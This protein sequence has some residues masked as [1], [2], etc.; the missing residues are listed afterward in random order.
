[1]K[2]SVQELTNH[3][4]VDH[5]L[6]ATLDSTEAFEGP[7]KLLEIWFYPNSESVPGAK[8]LRSISVETWVSILKLVNCEVLSIKSTDMV[9]AFLLSESSMFVYDFR[10]TLKTCGTTTTLFCLPRLF[11][12]VK[13]ELNWDFSVPND[14]KQRLEPYK[15][16]YS[17]RAFMFPSKQV[18]IHQNWMDEVDYLNKIFIKGKSYVVG[19]YD[20]R[21]HWHL[22]FTETNNFISNNDVNENSDATL[23]NSLVLDNDETMEILMT[24][25]EPSCAQQFV[26]NRQID[27]NEKVDKKPEDDA[28]DEGHLLGYNMTKRTGLDNIYELDSK[29][30]FH[31][32]AFAFSPCGYSSNMIIDDQY[33]YTLHITPENGWSYASF[34]SNV[35]TSKLTINQDNAQVLQ[36]VLKVFQP[37]EFCVTFFTRSAVLDDKLLA[38]DQQLSQYVK[39]D[40]IVYDLGDYHLLYIKF[41]RLV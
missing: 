7:E 2:I 23:H 19:R 11:E 13:D 40:K 22:Y 30:S 21:E 5:Q 37:S 17:R 34:E 18:P 32:D 38:I 16:F 20:D 8:N 27:I 36:R 28:D 3:S 26:S 12:I 15:V 9:D 1:M 35:P 25:L 39:R 31:H 4:Y 24:Q 33:Y 41:E 6:S 14:E 10:L 29:T